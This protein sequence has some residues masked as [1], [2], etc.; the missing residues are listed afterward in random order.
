M[1]KTENTKV[2]TTSTMRGKNIDDYID[3]LE[4]ITLCL[5]ELERTITTVSIT[6][7]ISLLVAIC[8]IAFVK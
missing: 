3:D 2:K 4:R 8:I 6:L 7:V 5:G 1:Y